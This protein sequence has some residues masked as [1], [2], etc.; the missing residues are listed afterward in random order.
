MSGPH[1]FVNGVVLR[2]RPPSV[3]H[4]TYITK[5]MG[6]IDALVSISCLFVALLYIV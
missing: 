4:T 2:Y 6:Q 3:D 5:A 1:D